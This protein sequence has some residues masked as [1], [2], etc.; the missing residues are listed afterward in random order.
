MKYIILASFFIFL[1]KAYCQAP[2]NDGNWNTTTPYL[3]DEFINTV[4]WTMLSTPWKQW[5][6]EQFQPNSQ[7]VSIDP[8]GTGTLKLK[9]TKSPD[10]NGGFNYFTGGLTTGGQTGGH[11]Y[12]YG[13]Y[14]IKCKVPKG[15]GIWPAFWL[16]G[17]D[18]NN[19]FCNIPGTEG[20]SE[21]I[22]IL[23]NSDMVNDDYWGYNWHFTYDDCSVYSKSN[24]TII[25]N[26]V[27]PAELPLPNISTST[28]YHTYAVE[29]L[30]GIL[31][32]YFDGEPMVEALYENY[33]PHH[34]RKEINITFQIQPEGNSL[35]PDATTPYSAEYLVDYV[36]VYEL[37]DNEAYINESIQNQTDITSYSYS[38]K[39]SITVQTGSNIVL[40][41]QKFSMRAINSIE[42]HGDFTVEVGSE[43]TAITHEKP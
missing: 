29:W 12:P 4:N 20:H 25:N 26:I 42:I 30:P 28:S 27:Y 2:L 15:K 18:L 6:Q 34:D 38:L 3:D 36:H 33:I 13:F 32:F 8:S 43:L 23:E 16:Y 11:D 19:P 31:V 5:G 37:I 10:G 35:S 14:E 22:D 1:G 24:T 21:E 9:M 7:Y 40:T 39:N 17:K 41:N